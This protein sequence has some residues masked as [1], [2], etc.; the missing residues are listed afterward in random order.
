MKKEITTESG[1]RV[2]IEIPADYRPRNEV[3]ITIHYDT[4]S[5]FATYLMSNGELAGLLPVRNYNRKHIAE[6]RKHG[7]SLSSWVIPSINGIIT[8]A[9][10]DAIKKILRV[11]PRSAAKKAEEKA[12][13]NWTLAYNKAETYRLNSDTR[14]YPAAAKAR[15]LWSELKINYPEAVA[16][17]T[18][19]AKSENEQA[20]EAR[21]N[22][23]D[24][25]AVQ[26]KLELRD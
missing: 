11:D 15:K 8:A 1:R 19:T 24:K 23:I 17:I 5:T 3:I 22:G 2:E 18:G 4:D 14:H 21:E 7:V 20:V 25:N 9:D 13:I 12:I 16:E 26:K 6:W 10:A